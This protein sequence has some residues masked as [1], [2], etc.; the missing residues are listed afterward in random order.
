M[1]STLLAPHWM[2]HRSM[3]IKII[4]LITSL[5]GFCF[6]LLEIHGLVRG[7]K[8]N[9][10]DLISWKRATSMNSIHYHLNVGATHKQL[11]WKCNLLDHESLRQQNRIHDM[12]TCRHK[13]SVLSQ[14]NHQIINLTQSFHESNCTERMQEVFDYSSR[15]SNTSSNMTQVGTKVV[16]I[17]ECYGSRAFLS[18]RERWWFIAVSNCDSSK[19]LRLKY[20]ITMTNDNV[21]S[22]NR[23]F[24]ADQL[25][26]CVFSCVSHVSLI[27]VG[28]MMRTVH[29]FLTSL[30]S[31][32]QQN[33]YSPVSWLW[34]LVLIPFSGSHSLSQMFSRRMLDS[35]SFT[36]SCL[37][38]PPS[39]PV[40]FFACNQNKT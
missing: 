29:P 14:S 33:D 23:H 13:E 28:K 21:T 7:G 31:L 25:C 9:T 3:T 8:I 34:I 16:P 36:S 37:P 12:Q 15:G 20:R 6:C 30:V 11:T 32:C 19:G 24:S 2:L 38:H 4:K 27:V 5:S 22:W 39:L 10:W 1:T 26:K 17:I 40:S 35:V 18:R